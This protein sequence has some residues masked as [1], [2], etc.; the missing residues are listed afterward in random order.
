MTTEHKTPK[1]LYKEMWDKFDED[2]AKGRSMAWTN[3]QRSLSKN[4]SELVPAYFTAK[5][6]MSVV[7]DI[8]QWT[9]NDKQSETGNPLDAM[10][11]WLS[12]KIELSRTPLEVV[13]KIS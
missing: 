2:R 11:D 9:K 5:E 7:S 12:G 10:S 6:L 3:L 4:A 1:Q 13:R 8:E